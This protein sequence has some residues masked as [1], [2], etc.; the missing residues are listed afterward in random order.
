MHFEKVNRGLAGERVPHRRPTININTRGVTVPHANADANQDADAD[1][2]AVWDIHE[3]WNGCEWWLW[4]G[5]G[6]LPSTAARFAIC[7][8]W[9]AK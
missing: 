6:S 8:A 5:I 3:S 1:A 7:I 9:T 4:F 2:D